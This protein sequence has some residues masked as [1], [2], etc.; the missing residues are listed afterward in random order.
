MQLKFD[1]HFKTTLKRLEE[2]GWE[3]TECAHANAKWCTKKINE[4]DIATI[5]D[6]QD[7]CLYVAIYDNFADLNFAIAICEE[8]KKLEVN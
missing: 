1:T 4:K 5:Y 3:I 6:Y 7:K 8:L 2:N